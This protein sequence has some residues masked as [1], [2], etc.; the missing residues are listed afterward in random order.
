MLFNLALGLGV[1]YWLLVLI[2]ARLLSEAHAER[3]A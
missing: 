1:A 2:K 3:F